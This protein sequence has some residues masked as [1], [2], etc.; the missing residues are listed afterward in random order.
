MRYYTTLNGERREIEIQENNGAYIVTLGD[1]TYSIDCEELASGLYLSLLVEGRSYTV[2]TKRS[3]GANR[4]LTRFGGDFLEVIVRTELQERAAARRAEVKATGPWT[5]ASPMP[6]I[7]IQLPHAVGDRVEKGETVAVVEAMK[8][9]NELPA[10]I[11]GVLTAIHVKQGTAIE[12][13]GLILTV[14]PAT[15]EA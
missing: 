12:T 1:R 4:W 13:R 5:L 6:G 14:E 11:D 3:E 7:V 9:Q 8:M 15:D 2:E 10:E